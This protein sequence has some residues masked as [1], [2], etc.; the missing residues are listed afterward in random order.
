MKDNLKKNT[1]TQSN[2]CFILKSMLIPFN[3]SLRRWENLVSSLNCFGNIDNER[4]IYSSEIGTLSRFKSF[5]CKI[6][7]YYK[8]QQ[9]KSWFLIRIQD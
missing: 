8:N 6:A 4:Y 7:H 3:F 1:K 5:Y 9:L 2:G